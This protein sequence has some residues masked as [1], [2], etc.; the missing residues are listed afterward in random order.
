[1][2]YTAAD[3]AQVGSA[4]LMVD[5]INRG[6]QLMNQTLANSKI[7]ASIRLVGTLQTNY[8]E[9]GNGTTDLA[10]LSTPADPQMADLK[11][12]AKAAG[13][14]ITDVIV[15]AMAGLGGITQVNYNV[16]LLQFLDNGVLSHELGHTFGGGHQHSQD[17]ANAPAAYEGDLTFNGATYSGAIGGNLNYFSNP[18]VFFYGQPTGIAGFG[19]TA[20]NNALAMNA[21]APS[22]AAISPTLT[23]DTTGPTAELGSLWSPNT[24]TG[25]GSI[26]FQV[27]YTDG[28]GVSVASFGNNN[29]TVTGPNGFS[30]AATLTSIDDPSVNYGYHLVTYTVATPGAVD[31]L[32]GYTFSI[33][34]NS[35]ADT[36]GNSTPAGKIGGPTPLSPDYA[37]SDFVHSAEI[38]DLAGQTWQITDEVGV[39]YQSAYFDPAIYHFSVSQDTTI[40]VNAPENTTAGVPLTVA[41]SQDLNGNLVEDNGEQVAPA[42]P[43]VWNL[44]AGK[45][46]YFTFSCWQAGAVPYGFFTASVTSSLPAIVK[47]ATGSISGSIFSDT[48]SN[49]VRDAG[50]PAIQLAAVQLTGTDSSGNAVSLMAYTD[51]TGNYAFNNLAPSSAAGYTLTEFPVY[52]G[53]ATLPQGTNTA[54]TL[55]GTGAGASINSVVVQPGAAGTGY[56]FSDRPLAPLIT[57]TLSGRVYLDPTGQGIATDPNDVAIPGVMITLTGNDSNGNAINL[58]ATSDANGNYTFISVPQSDSTNG[59]ALNIIQPTTTQLAQSV[60]GNLGAVGVGPTGLTGIIVNGVAGTGYDFPQSALTNTPPAATNQT[61]AT[62]QNGTVTGN[63]TGN[64]TAPAA[65]AAI[66][67]KTLEVSAAA[68]AATAANTT[69]V[70]LIPNTGPAHAQSF[71]LTSDGSFTYVPVK[72]F[73]GT[74]S[75]QYELISSNGSASVATETIKIAHVNQPPTFSTELDGPVFT[76]AKNAVMIDL[77][78]RVTDVDSTKM[79]Y[80][81]TKVVGG[82]AV[83]RNNG[84]V[85]YTPNRRFYGIASV[86]FKASDGKAATTL[87]Q[88]ICVCRVDVGPTARNHRARSGA[89]GVTI[90]AL[91]NDSNPIGG[92]LQIVGVTAPQNGAATI[93]TSGTKQRISYKP[94]ANFSGTD[95]FEYEVMDLAG[96]TSWATVSIVVHQPRSHGQLSSLDDLSL[97]IVTT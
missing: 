76:S 61:V 18:N 39:K 36:A 7:A 85:V 84:T 26:T 41:V 23:P 17:T 29:I 59:Y 1:M 96:K 32:G 92:P 2:G 49:G 75:F 6:V 78:D 14:D 34:A 93:V 65:N 30:S 68:V 51:A 21:R 28:S 52:S 86:T 54:G 25:A 73:F 55:G 15:T 63:V 77:H 56:V 47:P 70:V 62:A 66:V 19:A 80:R 12:A 88:A 89:A 64:T 38:G 90:N 37:G 10:H 22:L 8:V 72:N 58:T 13:A 87:S 46:Y 5:K 95:T 94:N 43:K 50:E 60:I 20:T 24:G 71:K 45:N 57:T 82:T 69:T 3:V 27:V 67:V 79:K 91:A 83:L 33:N 4:Q 9:S 11:S 35:V 44:K 97:S 74:D 48:N 53:T 42:A 16:I 81:I 31:T 40:T